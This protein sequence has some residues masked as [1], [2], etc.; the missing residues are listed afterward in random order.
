MPGYINFSNVTH[1]AHLLEQS[2]SYTADVYE[3]RRL[4]FNYPTNSVHRTVFVFL[5]T[6]LEGGAES[7][8]EMYR[9]D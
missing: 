4:F 2:P 1:R 5:P 8:N 6:H 7:N 3:F 9:I